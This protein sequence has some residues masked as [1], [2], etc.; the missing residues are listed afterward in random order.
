ME[1]VSVLA[2]VLV[3]QRVPRPEGGWLAE[4]V[5]YSN[6]SWMDSEWSRPSFF[7]RSLVRS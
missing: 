5:V 7:R 6:F 3:L 4:V 1:L 2:K